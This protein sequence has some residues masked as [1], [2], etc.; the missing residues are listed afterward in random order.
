MESKRK[1]VKIS[2]K[3]ERMYRGK[4]RDIERKRQITRERDIERD[5]EL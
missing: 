4:K 3:L 5:E 2:Q 1:C